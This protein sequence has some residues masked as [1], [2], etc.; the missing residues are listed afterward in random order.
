MK[1]YSAYKL[2]QQLHYYRITYLI[3]DQNHYSIDKISIFEA[4]VG[5]TFWFLI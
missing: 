2:F 5:V 4:L 1:Q 3:S